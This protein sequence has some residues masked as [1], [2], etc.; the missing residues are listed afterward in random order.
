MPD[1]RNPS[2]CYPGEAKYPLKNKQGYTDIV[3]YHECRLYTA[4]EI[5]V[6]NDYA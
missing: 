4:E 2:E 3:R 5:A 6:D 1:L